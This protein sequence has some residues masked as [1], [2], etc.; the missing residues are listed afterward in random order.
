MQIYKLTR[1]DSRAT[2]EI[3]AVGP[4]EAIQ[5][6]VG[7]SLQN[8]RL[9]SWSGTSREYEGMVRTGPPQD[10]GVIPFIEVRFTTEIV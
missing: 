7:D 1:D 5:S 9:E 2:T 10:H 6:W 8:L 3:E 4:T